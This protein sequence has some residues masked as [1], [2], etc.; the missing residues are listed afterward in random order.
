[1]RPH[2]AANLL[3]LLTGFTAAPHAV[4]LKGY[5]W[6]DIKPII[7]T[8]SLQKTSIRTKINLVPNPALQR[9]YGVQ[10]KYTK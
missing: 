2:A 5:D 7:P 8:P 4:K 3:S 1:M 6:I 10:I 9:G